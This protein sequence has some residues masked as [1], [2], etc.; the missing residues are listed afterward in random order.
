MANDDERSCKVLKTMLEE[1]LD[2]PNKEFLS[3]LRD[4]FDKTGQSDVYGW[5]EIG[6]RADDFKEEIFLVYEYLSEYEIAKTGLYGVGGFHR[7]FSEYVVKLQSKAFYDRL[8]NQ[9]WREL[10]SGK[11][12]LMRQAKIQID[13]LTSDRARTLAWLL[14]K[15]EF[16]T[17]QFYLHVEE[18]CG[19]IRIRKDDE[20]KV[21]ND[22]N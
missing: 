21:D 19:L 6:K 11:P 9:A 13:S 12:D 4:Y 7:E 2:K 20:G 1:K 17:D 15:Y 3:L 16:G 8:I 5:T 10:N 22:N 14:S 18:Y